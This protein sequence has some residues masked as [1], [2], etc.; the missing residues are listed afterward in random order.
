MLL[1]HI[2][3]HLSFGI[4]VIRQ[5]TSPKALTKYIDVCALCG[6]K[7]EFKA[8]RTFDHFL[9]TTKEGKTE[10]KNG[11]VLC[12]D[13]NS[14]VKTGKHPSKLFKEH[15]EMEANLTTNYLEN[16]KVKDI[17]IQGKKNE[18]KQSYVTVFKAYAEQLLGRP[19]KG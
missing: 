10:F 4:T 17:F 14:I 18:P 12:E 2:N 15:P 9:P 6:D 1:N 5:G 19:L 11:I 3:N 7:L 8:E 13:C 16:P